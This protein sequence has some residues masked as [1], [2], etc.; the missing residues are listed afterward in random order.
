M[1]CFL[2][3]CIV[4]MVVG[5]M[6]HAPLFGWEEESSPQRPSRQ[7]EARPDPKDLDYIPSQAVAAVVAYPRRVLT[8]DAWEL[9]PV[10]ILSAQ[11]QQ[12]F[13]FDPV[14]IVCALMVVELALPQPPQVGIL[15][16]FATPF[17]PEKLLM[18]LKE[19]TVPEQ[20]DG[21]PYYRSKKPVD[22][23]LFLP[24][25][26]TLLLGHDALLR[27]MV[28][29]RAAPKPGPLSR[30]LTGTEP[31]PDVVVLVDFK[32]LR[33]LAAAQ[34]AMV[35]LE[36]GFE[37]LRKI[38]PLLSSGQVKLNLVKTPEILLAVQAEDETAAKELESILKDLFQNA[39]EA[40]VRQTVV[41]RR[42]EDPVEKATA[43]YV[44]RI[45]DR[46][47]KTL[48]PVR[49]GDTLKIELRDSSSMQM[50]SIGI[51]TSLLLPAVQSAREAARRTQAMNQMKQLGLAMHMYHASHQQFPARANFDPKGR[52]LLSW[53]VHLLPYLEEEA[54]Y[55]EFH[56]DEPWDSPHNRK[57]I[58]RMPAIF[59]TLGTQT[60][61]GTTQYVGLVGKGTFFEG[62]VGR[63]IIDIRDGMSNTMMLVEVDPDQ[64]VIWTKPEDLPF[65]PKR[66][67]AGLGHA[68]RGGFCVLFCDGS[69][70]FIGQQTDPEVIRHLA[71]IGDDK[72]IGTPQLDQ[73]DK[74]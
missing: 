45:L 25:D 55:R 7:T 6:I 66:P 20:L 74:N 32:P 29:H 15:A 46:L 2:R 61:P 18:S 31:I 59:Q 40:I 43:Q 39:K 8:S 42:T 73:P 38:P 10:E 5:P 26:H 53:R 44:Q 67:L 51:T 11:G 62:T 71:I 23:S 48:Q 12:E 57:L 49:K 21:K 37:S 9:F 17:N 50:A 28:A 72:P 60:K 4:W 35:P 63:K 68:H 64:A 70:R 24:D 13:G 16:R 52:P 47:F 3:V 58:V 34:L 41:A 14:E 19:N 1:K 56:L 30:M 54:L 22:I 69:V 27:K 36:P 65:D 33:D